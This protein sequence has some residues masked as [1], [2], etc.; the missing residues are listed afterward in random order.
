MRPSETH[1]IE[2]YRHALEVGG[3]G[4]LEQR[5]DLIDGA[6]STGHRV[7]L[8][9]ERDNSDPDPLRIQLLQQP[10]RAHDL[11]RQDGVLG[12]GVHRVQDRDQRCLLLTQGTVTVNVD[13]ARVARGA[14]DIDDEHQVEVSRTIAGGGHPRQRRK[15]CSAPH[16]LVWG[17]RIHHDADPTVLGREDT[18]LGCEGRG[19]TAEQQGEGCRPRFLPPPARI[20]AHQGG[21]NLR[22]ATWRCRRP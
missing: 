17:G 14:R 18:F 20:S 1:G 3:E 5:V 7:D 22:A 13:A 21:P 12:V 16:D 6:A 19:C 11:C 15:I 8:S 2:R 4:V 9:R 10:P